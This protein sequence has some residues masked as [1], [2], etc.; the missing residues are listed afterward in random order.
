MKKLIKYFLP[1]LS[2]DTPTA[3]NNRPKI[4]RNS[5][6]LNDLDESLSECGPFAVDIR[7]LTMVQIQEHFRT[8]RLTSVDL[9]RCYLN[10][11]AEIDVYLRSV[12]EVN[13]DAISLAERADWE[14]SAGYASIWLSIPYKIRLFFRL[15]ENPIHGIPIL[16]K[17]NIGTADSMQTTAGALA[18][19]NLKPLV[20]AD[21]VTRLRNA[22]A[23]I[24]GKASLSE[25][26]K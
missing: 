3:I 12:I 13:P 9:T 20:D 8:G 14:R 19:E 21:V 26:A 11:I 2:L 16:L 5:D 24:L 18:L 1:S 22:G 15:S 7:E 10:R 25:W 23:I 4:N 6:E 17:D